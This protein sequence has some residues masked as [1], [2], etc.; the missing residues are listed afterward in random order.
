MDDSVYD[1]AQKEMITYPTQA[2]NINDQPVKYGPVLY[3]VLHEVASRVNGAQYLI[4]V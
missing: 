3:D 1:P 4:G 2:A